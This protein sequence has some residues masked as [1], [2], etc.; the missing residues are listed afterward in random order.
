MFTR[1]SSD[2]IDRPLPLTQLVTAPN[3]LALAPMTNCLSHDD[4]TISDAEIHWYRSKGEAGFG[5]VVTGGLSVSPGGQIRRNQPRIDD[6]RFS[7]GLQR[8]TEARY[9][10]T[11]LLA[12][13]LH[14]GLRVNPAWSGHAHERVGPSAGPGVRE[15]SDIEVESLVEEYVA[16]A[17]R[18]V[19]AGFDGVDIHAAH[20]YLP[21]QF[22]SVEENTRAGRYGGDFEG[23]SRFTLEL[24]R[25]FRAELPA[26]TVIQLRI[27]AED[28]RQSRGI[29]LDESALLAELGAEAGADLISLSVWDIHKPAQKHPHTTPVEHVKARLGSTVPLAVAGKIW[30]AADAQLGFSQGADQLAIGRAAIFHRDAPRYLRTTGIDPRRPPMSRTALSR[31]GVQP[32]FLDY[33]ADKWNDFLIPEA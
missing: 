3:R 33:L 21:A 27:S 4:G 12:Q 26:G 5:T 25:R 2:L 20:G 1:P 7:P 6:D 30:N 15:L 14:G 24:V 19:E 32:A 17:L 29:D 13:L 10:G 22:L 16:C 23:R 11:V 18:A 9:A 28:V 8:L 31:E